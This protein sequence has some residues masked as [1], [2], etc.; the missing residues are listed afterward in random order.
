MTVVNTQKRTQSRPHEFPRCQSA[1]LPSFGQWTCDP[2]RRI[3]VQGG[4][5]AQQDEPEADR[6]KA[7]TPS[8]VEALVHAIEEL[9]SQ[10]ADAGHD[11]IARSLSEN[12]GGRASRPGTPLR[13]T[14]SM[15]AVVLD[16]CDEHR[17]N[18]HEGCNDMG[19]ERPTSVHPQSGGAMQP[20][21]CGA[22]G[23]VSQQCT[24]P[25][26]AE[27]GCSTVDKEARLGAAN[28]ISPA[29]GVGGLRSPDSDRFTDA[30]DWPD[31]DQDNS[32]CDLEHPGDS[33]AAPNRQQEQ[34]HQELC[35]DVAPAT[36]EVPHT[37]LDRAN[38][39]SCWDAATQAP[40]RVHFESIQL[41]PQVND[42]IQ[43][44]YESSPWTQ[45]G[46]FKSTVR[47]SFWKRRWW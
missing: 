7:E 26:N 34:R 47:L 11:G 35:D 45:L 5:K 33:T 27:M 30:A 46:S 17:Q 42:A 20:D 10:A 32:A 41:G 12:F 14:R 8:K 40:P 38:S 13:P 21:I 25:T 1:C 44:D 3:L 36:A 37:D 9:I 22:P 24:A 28:L 16:I 39:S 18:G 15:S 19:A 4:A 31:P 43:R 23:L 29:D 2:A 6:L